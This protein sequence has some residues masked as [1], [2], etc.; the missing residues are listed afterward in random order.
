M[1]HINDEIDDMAKNVIQIERATDGLT[2]LMQDP[3]FLSRQ[4]ERLLN[5][6]YRIVGAGHFLN[7]IVT[8]AFL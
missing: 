4:I 2:D 3:Q 5:I 8:K 1:R 7:V 6:L